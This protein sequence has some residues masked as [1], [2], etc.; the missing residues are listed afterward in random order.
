VKSSHYGFAKADLNA[1]AAD[2]AASLQREPVVV[3]PAD[4]GQP[5]AR[6]G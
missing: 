1:L 5:D 6:P 3:A 2:L 4:D